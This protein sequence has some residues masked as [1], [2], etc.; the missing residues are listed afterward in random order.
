MPAFGELQSTSEDVIYMEGAARLFGGDRLQDLAQ[1]NE[2]MSALERRVALLGVLHSALGTR[3]VLVRIGSENE[4][5]GLR[6]L[7]FVASG[8]GLPTRKLG[9]VSVIGPVRMDYGRTIATVRE[10]A[11]QLSRYVE[12]VYEG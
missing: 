5:A 2:L 11:L 12:D 7:A 6:S 8:Y 10:A 3:D 9:T 4:L 1:I